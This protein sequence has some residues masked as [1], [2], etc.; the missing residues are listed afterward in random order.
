MVTLSV[1]NDNMPSTFVDDGKET[2][3]E[4]LPDDTVLIIGSGP[5]GLVLATVLSHFG[6]KSLLL[7]RNDTTTR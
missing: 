5:V 4:N 6:V 1:E 7:E 3:E 2:P